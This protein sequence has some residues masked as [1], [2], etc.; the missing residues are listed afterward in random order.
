VTITLPYIAKGISEDKLKIHYWNPAKE[1]WEALESTIDK[2][3]MLISA[4][5][6]H[7]SLY[8]VLVPDDALRAAAD[9]DAAFAFRDL[10]VF[11]NP[12][13]A[14]AKPTI[15]L[16]VGKADQVIIKIYNVAGQQ[17]HE[18]SID[19]APQVIDFQYAYEYAWDEHIPSGVYFYVVEAKKGGQ[20][21]IRRTGKM[22]VVR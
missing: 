12:A 14:G 18:A 8:Q 10:Y 9:P 1:E 7:F 13:R 15:H 5:T 19:R 16:P 17:V 11:P 2:E 3:N 21:S 20:S 6:M 22:A 4:R